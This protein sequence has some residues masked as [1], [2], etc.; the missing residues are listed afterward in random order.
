MPDR[1]PAVKLVKLAPDPLNPVAVNTP[2]LGLYW[3]LVELVY[4]VL[5]VP[6]VAAANKG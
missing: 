2:V 5:I 4:S 3:Y 1:L 6:E